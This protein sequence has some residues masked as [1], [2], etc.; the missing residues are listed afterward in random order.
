MRTTIK[1]K[2]A[3]AKIAAFNKNTGKSMTNIPY[4]MK[5]LAIR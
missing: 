3:P 2:N 1:T 5:K 4:D